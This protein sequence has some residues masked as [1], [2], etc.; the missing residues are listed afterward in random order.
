[1]I[2]YAE[3]A[4]RA[5]TRLGSEGS[6]VCGTWCGSWCRHARRGGTGAVRADDSRGCSKRR[7]VKA[8]GID[9]AATWAVFAMD[10]LRSAKLVMEPEAPPAVACRRGDRRRDRRWRQGEATCG[11]WDELLRR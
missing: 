4:S 10:P 3:G 11:R 6:G 1:M 8:S 7:T 9:G 5:K 2:P